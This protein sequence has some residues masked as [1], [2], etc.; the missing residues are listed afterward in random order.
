LYSVIGVVRIACVHA[1]ISILIIRANDLNIGIHPVCPDVGKDIAD[2]LG[3]QM[4][5]ENTGEQESQED[6]FEGFEKFFDHIG[7]CAMK[8]IDLS[9]SKYTTYCGS[10]DE[11]TYSR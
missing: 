2:G 4:I 6:P 3:A 9:S 7:S 8:R 10:N 5:T 11:T 1:E